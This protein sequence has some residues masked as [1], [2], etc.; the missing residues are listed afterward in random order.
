MGVKSALTLSCIVPFEVSLVHVV[1]G[2]APIM[3]YVWVVFLIYRE[4]IKGV[5]KWL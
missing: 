5:L 1:A 3:L 4:Y 2:S